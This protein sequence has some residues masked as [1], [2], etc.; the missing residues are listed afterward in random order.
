MNHPATI[1][2]AYPDKIQARLEARNRERARDIPSSVNGLARELVFEDLKLW[3]IGELKVSFKRGN[4]ELLSKIAEA[5][6]ASTE[7]GNIPF[8]SRHPHTHTS[9]PRSPPDPT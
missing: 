2:E 1:M 4:P 3:R 7:F 9:S 5:A 6:S 8:H